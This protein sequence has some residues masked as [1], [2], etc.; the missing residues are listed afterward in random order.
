MEVLTTKNLIKRH[1]AI[2]IA[3]AALA[4]FASARPAFGVAAGNDPR[5]YSACVFASITTDVTADNVGVLLN[6]CR[7]AFPS[8][9]SSFAKT[10]PTVGHCYDSYEPNAANRKAAV[11]LFEACSEYFL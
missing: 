3:A 5:D 9:S 11:A 7:S 2:F 1:S 4:W 8:K 10:W 6:D